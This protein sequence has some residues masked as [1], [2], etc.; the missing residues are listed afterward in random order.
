VE[1]LAG[2]RVIM[3]ED[4]TTTGG[5]VLRAIQIAREAEAVV[6]TVVT[7]VD[8][9]EGAAENLRPEG[10][11]LRAVYNADDFRASA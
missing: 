5:S 4:V 10:I 3:L 7:L 11:S 1:A 8:R 6:D 9:L 2:K